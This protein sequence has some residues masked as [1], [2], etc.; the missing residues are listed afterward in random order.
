MGS[1]W[2]SAATERWL[3]WRHATGRTDKSGRWIESPLCRSRRRSDNDIPVLYPGLSHSNPHFIQLSITLLTLLS[4][5]FCAT[6]WCFLCLSTVALC[7]HAKIMPSIGN[8]QLVLMKSLLRMVFLPPLFSLGCDMFVPASLSASSAVFLPL[9]FSLYVIFHHY[10][11]AK[12]FISTSTSFVTLRT[13]G[14]QPID[15]SV[16]FLHFSHFPIPPKYVPLPFLLTPLR[17]SFAGD[18]RAFVCNICE[19]KWNKSF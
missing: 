5:W 6:L 19:K 3:P 4:F 10:N 11:C 15:Q 1:A 13:H 17:T 8:L 18:C 14:V 12:H 2:L 7:T 9:S 16:W